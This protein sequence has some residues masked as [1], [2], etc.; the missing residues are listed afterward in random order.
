MIVRESV[1]PPYSVP[2]PVDLSFSIMSRIQGIFTPNIVPLDAHGQIHEGELRRYVDWLIERGVHGLYPN[3]STGEFVRFNA[4]G[5]QA[6]LAEGCLYGWHLWGA[7]AA[8]R[9]QLGAAKNELLTPPV[10]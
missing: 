5:L 2:S 6:I 9:A 8:A 7:E 1:I 4:A 3:G 10:E